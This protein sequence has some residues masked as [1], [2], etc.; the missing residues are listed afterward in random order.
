MNR[1]K[2]IAVV[3]SLSV[4]CV[5]AAGTGAAWAKNG[6]SEKFDP[7]PVSSDW[8]QRDMKGTYAYFVSGKDWVGV[9]KYDADDDTPLFAKASDQYAACYETAY[10]VGS[11]LYVVKGFAKDVDDIGK[12]REMVESISYPGNPALNENSSDSNGK[13]AGDEDSDQDGSSD[14]SNDSSDSSVGGNNS[15]SGKDTSGEDN[16]ADD[17]ISTSTITLKDS[18]GNTVDIQRF[19]HSDYSEEYRGYDGIGYT[20]DD[21]YYFYDEN[22]NP[23]TA[24]NDSTHYFGN[25]LE[26][27]T[28]ESSDGDTVTV[29]QTTN[30]DY[31]YQDENGTGFSDNGDGTWTDENGND[32]TEIN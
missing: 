12:V 20:T 23:Y 5:T 26:Q 6:G 4:F 15:S 8:E 14:A 31:Y 16:S 18:D 24:L 21:G 11:D 29:T 30:G 22:G 17:T 1:K 9:Y 13:T 7:Q 2:L 25:E 32:Y 10:S 28:L 27:H 19:L 3:A